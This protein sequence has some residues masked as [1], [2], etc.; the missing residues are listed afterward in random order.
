MVSLYKGHKY[1]L[2]LFIKTQRAQYFKNLKNNKRHD[3][4]ESGEIQVP[5]NLKTAK[6][7]GQFFVYD[8][9]HLNEVKN[10]ILNKNK[11]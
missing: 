10:Q 4:K 6:K 3:Y 2:S 1:I 9:N 7:C 11:A 5:L 8:E